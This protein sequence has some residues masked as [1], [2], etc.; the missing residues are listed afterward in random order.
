MYAGNRRS[1]EHHARPIIRDRRGATGD[2]SWPISG[3]PTN[4]HPR[5]RTGASENVGAFPLHDYPQLER[6]V[7]R[8]YE[9][10][11]SIDGA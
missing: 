11:E 5:H 1:T 2:G 8:R 3:K 7:R 9:P 10:V 6:F 4:V